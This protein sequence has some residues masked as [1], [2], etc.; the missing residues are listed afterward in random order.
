MK[1]Q[2]KL[3]ERLPFFLVCFLSDVL[4]GTVFKAIENEVMLFKIRRKMRQAGFLW[5]SPKTVLFFPKV[6]TSGFVIYKICKILGYKMICNKSQPCDLVIDWRCETQ[7]TEDNVLKNLN[8]KKPV[9]NYN[10][11]DI[12]KQKVEEV[13]RRVFGY[14]SAIDPLIHEGRCV[15]KS[16]NNATHDGRIINCPI[17][18]QEKGFIYQKLINNQCDKDYIYDIRVP[19]IK[20]KIPCVYLKYRSI[21]DRF[22]HIVKTEIENPGRLFSPEEIEKIILFARNLYLDYGELDVL[23]DHDSGLLYIVDANTTPYG[24]SK[25][26]QFDKKFEALTMLARTFDEVFFYA[27]R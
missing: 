13:F 22:K 23:R 3:R 16:N 8:E 17:E 26:K 10:C 11:R 27:E 2:D 5:P 14:S 1:F 7:R 20:E 21:H 19:I 6:P 24:P 12:S 15:V 25:I 18:K 4:Y 9:L